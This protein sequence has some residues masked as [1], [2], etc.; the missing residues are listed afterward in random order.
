MNKIVAIGCDHGGYELK[1]KMV[2][3]L[4][5]MNYDVVDCGC[6]DTG[7]VD[8][9]DIAKTLCKKITEGECEQGILI[10]GTG[11]GMS[12]AANKV[13]GIRC[14][15]CT[16]TYSATMAKEHNNANVIALGARIT[17]D[18]LAFCIV[19]SYLSASFAGG[20]HENRVSKIT[21]LENNNLY[22]L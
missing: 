12:I 16:D 9:P 11:I 21:A 7:S 17:G 15:H 8:Y 2:K 18:E 14:A 19:K 10:C 1:I 6:Y 5:D 3:M 4:T 20:R 22:S 13:C